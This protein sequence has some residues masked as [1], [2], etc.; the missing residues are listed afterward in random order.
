[1]KCDKC[2]FVSFDYLSEC[3][4]CSADLTGTREQLGFSS[5]KSEVPFL[6]GALLKGG[7]QRDGLTQPAGGESEIS[8]KESVSRPGAGELFNS[9]SSGTEPAIAADQGTGPSPPAREELII[10]LSEADLESLSGFN[11]PIKGKEPRRNP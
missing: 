4:R 3:R 2:G 6:L 8:N 5:L 9:E 1:M 11:E 10:E 7:S